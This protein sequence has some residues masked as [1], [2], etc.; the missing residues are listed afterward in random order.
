MT[1]LTPQEVLRRQPVWVVLS[2]LFVGTE[3][4]GYDY[5]WIVK[6]LRASGYGLPELE[7]ILL[8]EVAPVFDR[9]IAPRTVPEMDGWGDES[10][11]REIQ[12]YLDNPSSPS[13]LQRWFGRP[14]RRR[15]EEPLAGRWATVQHWLRVT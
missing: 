2:E 1:M 15:M 13:L 4:R 5:A 11:V 9:D 10:V 12:A 6:A 14:R 7:A 3:L 8:D